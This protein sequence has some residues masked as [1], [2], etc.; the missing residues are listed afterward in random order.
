LIN[1]ELFYRYVEKSVNEVFNNKGY[2][3]KE[4]LP[5]TQQVINR[6]ISKSRQESSS[7]SLQE[8]DDISPRDSTKKIQHYEYLDII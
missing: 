2:A 1:L 8:S 7:L 5:N 3:A 4:R 6:E